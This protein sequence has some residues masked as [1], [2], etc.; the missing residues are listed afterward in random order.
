MAS[1]QRAVSIKATEPTT[2]R[3]G[4]VASARERSGRKSE[5]AWAGLETTGVVDSRAAA[6]NSRATPTLHGPPDGRLPGVL[7][8]SDRTFIAYGDVCGPPPRGPCPVGIERPWVANLNGYRST[9]TMPRQFSDRRGITQ[10]RRPAL[11]VLKRQ[12]STVVLLPRTAKP[13]STLRQ[14]RGATDTASRR[15]WR[16]QR[17]Y[18]M[19]SSSSSSSFSPSSLPSSTS[20]SPPSPELSVALSE[21]A[22][23]QSPPLKCPSTSSGITE[24]RLG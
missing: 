19:S 10:R 17:G 2:L 5:A 13:A 8:L 11:L 1:S 23:S 14:P 9:P 21:S 18:S 7:D 16:G 24:S 6:A 20:S 3:A 4:S 12:L 15:V 22:S